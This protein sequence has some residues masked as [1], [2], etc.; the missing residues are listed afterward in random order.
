MSTTIWYVSLCDRKKS[1]NF[2]LVRLVIGC[3]LLYQL[4]IAILTLKEEEE[5]EREEKR[6]AQ[7]ENYKNSIL[8]IPPPLHRIM[9]R[10]N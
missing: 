1:G 3:K 4:K 9:M 2:S 5:K 10:T 6:K 7:V 8:E